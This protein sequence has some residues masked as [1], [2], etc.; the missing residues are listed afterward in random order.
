VVAVH[1]AA[2]VAAVTVDANPHPRST[3]LLLNSKQNYRITS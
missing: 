2:V 1:T 3:S